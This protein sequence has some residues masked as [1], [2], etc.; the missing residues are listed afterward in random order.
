VIPNPAGA[1]NGGDHVPHSW[2]AV[3]VYRRPTGDPSGKL[4]AN[5][6]RSAQRFVRRL[7]GSSRPVVDRARNNE[8]ARQYFLGQRRYSLSC[9]ARN[10]VNKSG[11]NFHCARRQRRIRLS[12]RDTALQSRKSKD[13]TTDLSILPHPYDPASR[14]DEGIGLRKPAG[15]NMARVLG[16]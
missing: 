5:A 1:G 4:A 2:S 16:R 11:G 7:S 12:A 3:D 6:T 10:N 8:G 15:R 9:G 14:S 13:A